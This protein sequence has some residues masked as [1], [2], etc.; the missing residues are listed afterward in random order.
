MDCLRPEVRNLLEV[1]FRFSLNELSESVK[2]IVGCLL[3]SIWGCI[4][5]NPELL[6]STHLKNIGSPSFE[7]HGI[8]DE[9]RNLVMYEIL[10]WQYFPWIRKETYV[11]SL[12]RDWKWHHLFIAWL[13]SAIDNLSKK[14]S[15]LK[16]WW[17]SIP[18]IPFSINISPNVLIDNFPSIVS[19]L[20]FVVEKFNISPSNIVLEI[21]EQS[22]RDMENLTWK[23]RYLKSLWL[24][25][26][27]D[28]Y[29][30]KK[31]DR[32][33]VSC[34]LEAWVLDY[35]KLDWKK[36]HRI[37]KSGP[38]SV[39]FSE[40]KKIISKVKEKWT[41]VI[42]EHIC[43]EEIFMFA[44]SLWCDLFQWFNLSRPEPL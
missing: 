9:K 30:A 34:F 2:R 29:L 22:C 42:A 36:L 18:L 16:V 14:W 27:I 39:W 44:K 21:T 23:L 24:K 37:L 33:R 19:Y 20:S 10:V 41:I 31:S 32:D 12:H 11:D 13:I 26:A 15:I 6:L 35:L 7:I 28:D 5:I 3:P 38:N 8:H 25:I 40:L 4:G 17:L 1:S 43:G